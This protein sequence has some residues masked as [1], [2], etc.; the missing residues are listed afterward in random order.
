VN[1][2]SPVSSHVP[3]DGGGVHTVVHLA[4]HPDDEMIGAPATLFLLRDAGWRVVNITCGLGPP[5]SK[6]RREAEV[7]ES[8]RRAAFEL[9]IADVIGSEEALLAEVLRG[10][11]DFSPRLVVAPSPHDA[12]PGHEAVGRAAVAACERLDAQEGGPT[13]L[14]LWGLW[15]DLPFPTLAIAFGEHTLREILHCLEAH[16]GEL[17]RN[18]YRRLVTGRAEMNA[19]LGPERVFGFGSSARA[20]AG[21][22]FVELLTEVVRDAGT[23]SLGVRRWVQSADPL[24]AASA[25]TPQ[26]G[27]PPG[28]S[29]LDPPSPAR[30][31]ASW[32]HS[33]GTRR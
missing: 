10:I 6:G 20:T 9:R 31:V 24:G 4:P 33:S 2:A 32:L 8:C 25:R 29:R 12:H 22:E 7:R 23:W 18:D 27:A 30:S 21:G 1:S 11:T 19:S 28:Q 3:G 15:A 5:E 13:R 14:W 26:N 16:R 17:E